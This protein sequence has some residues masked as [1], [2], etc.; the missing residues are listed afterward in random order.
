MGWAKLLCSRQF[1]PETTTRA[2]QTI[3]RNARLQTQLIGDLLDVSRILRGKLSL[4]VL[5][6]NLVSPI[7]AAIE[8]MR[9]A[10]ESKSIHLETTIEP[11][12]RWVMGDPGRL[13]QVVWNLLSNAIKF[14]PEEG[15]IEIRLD[16]VGNQA[17]IQVKDT[18]KGIN[19]EFLPYIFEY[20]RQAD[21]SMTRTQG[22][23]GLG[24]AI[25]HHLVELH[26][27]TVS[28]ESPGEGQGATFT[29]LLPFQKRDSRPDEPEDTEAESSCTAPSTLDLQGLRIVLVDDELDT[30]EFLSFLLR[31]HNAEVQSF[32]AA[33]SAF[34]AFAE[35]PADILISDI[36]MPQEDGYSLLRRIRKL[37]TDQ[38]GTVPAIALTAYAREEDRQKA[39]D[40]GFQSHLAKPVNSTE[41]LNTILHL[42]RNQS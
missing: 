2:L 36:G 30:R 8:T 6:V 33:D 38:G 41:L 25:V 27:G 9:L 29:V 26:G 22:G 16:T 20:F 3:E 35:W 32:E 18:G 23:L 40:A 19:P 5:P 12:V 39:L 37:P 10:A 13:Q 4:E 31:Q 34:T 42:T 24:L 14:T 17:R 11:N 21:S 15:R 1:D 7:E 28:A